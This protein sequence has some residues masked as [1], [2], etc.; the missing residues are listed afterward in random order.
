MLALW[1]VAM[2]LSA[3]AEADDDGKFGFGI[4]TALP[5]QVQ[6]FVSETKKCSV[7]I[8]KR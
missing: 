6:K 1:L 7:E 2:A 3:L 5:E 4:Q 8:S